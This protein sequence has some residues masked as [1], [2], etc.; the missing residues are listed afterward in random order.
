MENLSPQFMKFRIQHNKQ[1]VLMQL[2]EHPWVKPVGDANKYKMFTAN[3]FARAT[4][5]KWIPIN[6]YSYSMLA[7]GEPELIDIKRKMAELSFEDFV[8]T[9][10]TKRSGVKGCRGYYKFLEVKPNLPGKI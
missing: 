9:L 6:F 4:N 1:A 8:G 5:G 3:F 2:W 10:L 7:P